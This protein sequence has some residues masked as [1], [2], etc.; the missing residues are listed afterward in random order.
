MSS[1]HALETRRRRKVTRMETFNII[2]L[3]IETQTVVLEEIRVSV[4][5]ND[6]KMEMNKYRANCQVINKPK[7]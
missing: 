4:Q 5:W 6:I 7:E 3:L 2:L 1:G